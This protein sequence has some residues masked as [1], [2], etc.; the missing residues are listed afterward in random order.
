MKIQNTTVMVTGGA[1]GLGEAC[2]RLFASEG[3]N[4]AILDM[5]AELGEALAKELCKNAVFHKTDVSDEQ[6]VQA[7]VD[8]TMAAFGKIHTV[9]NCAGI[10]IPSK[11]LVKGEPAPLSSFTKTIQVNLL[12]TIN[13][14]RLAAAQMLKNEPN[15][16]G[17][18]GV[19]INT[20]SIAAFEGQI[21]Q[22]SYTATKAGVAGMTLPIARE[23]A[24][25]GI[26]VNTIAP[27][28][29]ETPMMAS[30]PEKVRNSL[31]QMVPFPRRFG[32]S[33][34]YA[35]LAKHIVENAMINAE[36]IRL[37]GAIRM[38]AK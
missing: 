34:E 36:T 18:R 19:V 21:G 4:V 1:S 2:V 15:E 13:V 16:D 38:G 26:R 29:F 3:A 23:F 27:G 7:A 11:I 35:A 33:A 32:Q 8:A 31:I 20:A 17:E 30:L 5:N 12:G 24:D 14:I 22:T 9:I 10:V 28:L 37:D 6:N 25:Y